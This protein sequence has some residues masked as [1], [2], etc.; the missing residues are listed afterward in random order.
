MIFL[1]HLS[2][3]DSSTDRDG[4]WCMVN[5]MLKLLDDKCWHTNPPVRSAGIIL[6]THKNIRKPFIFRL[7]FFF[8]II[9]IVISVNIC[10]CM[11]DHVGRFSA[12]GHLQTVTPGRVSQRRS[13]CWGGIN[14]DRCCSM[15]ARPATPLGFPLANTGSILLSTK[16][17]Q[18]SYVERNRASFPSAYLGNAKRTKIQRD[19]RPKHVAGNKVA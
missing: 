12:L 14:S 10:F 11:L 5:R 17:L 2:H 7:W 4:F 13:N 6:Y 8:N 18:F 16:L 19:K 9:F 3:T 15:K 1:V